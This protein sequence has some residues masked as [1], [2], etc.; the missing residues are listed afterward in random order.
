MQRVAKRA[1]RL[2]IER[3]VF[4]SGGAR[5][6]PAGVD[7]ETARV[8]LAEFTRMAG[9]VCA[10]HGVTLVI[11]HLN[12]GETNTLNTLAEARDLCEGVDHPGVQMLVD[13]YH[14]G[15]EKENDQA[16][17]DLDGTLRHVHVAEVVGRV[18]PGAH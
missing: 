16:V 13:S 5:K 12:R 10:H 2:G 7:E 8:H 1:K 6:R 18:Q 4:G 14:Y 17:L 3:L 11:E 9:E 15:L